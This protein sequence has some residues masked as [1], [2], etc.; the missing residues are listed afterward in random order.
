MQELAAYLLDPAVFFYVLLAKLALFLL[1]FALLAR[2]SLRL[3]RWE[4]K[5]RRLLGQA[6]GGNLEEILHSVHGELAAVK[7][8]YTRVGRNQQALAEKVRTSLRGVS[9]LRYN[10]FHDTGSDLSYSLALL[11]ENRDGVV[12]SALYGR[13]ECRTYAK[14][15]KGGAS[16]YHLSDEESRVLGQAAENVQRGGDVLD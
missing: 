10:A 2:Q 11:D 14:P 7:A 9:L 16:S 4:K 6:P 3:S 12:L 8:G 15:I 13:E 1:L 5:Y